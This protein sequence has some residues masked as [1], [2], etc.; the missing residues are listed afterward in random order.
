MVLN[1]LARMLISAETLGPSAFARRLWRFVHQPQTFVDETTIATRT[2]FGHTLYL[3]A[4]DTSLRPALVRRGYWEPAVTR[5]LRRLLRPGQHVVEIGGNVGYYSVLFASGVT[6]TGRVTTFEPNPRMVDLLRRSV[7]ANE[8]QSIVHIEPLA[9]SDRPGRVTLHAL[10]KQ[11]GSS[12][13]YAFTAAELAEGHDRATSIEVEATSL[14]AFVGDEQPPP[15]L[16][17][18]DAEGAEP[19]IVAGMERL[20]AR[21]PRLQVVLEFRPDILGR[22]GHDPR[23]FLTKLAQLGFR[24]HLID[25]WGRIEPAAIERLLT[26]DGEELYLCR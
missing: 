3:D 8:K 22:A 1:A 20:I 10:A 13:L 18:I 19:A 12:S 23:A 16:V 17:K 7:A 4:R 11:Q 24:L 26:S 25:R 9:V 21:A 14:D 15:D 5:V 2:V 6:A